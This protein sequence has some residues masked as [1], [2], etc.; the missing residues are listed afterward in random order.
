M[1][2]TSAALRASISAALSEAFRTKGRVDARAVVLRL[3]VVLASRLFEVVV[4]AVVDVPRHRRRPG[5]GFRAEGGRLVGEK[6][7]TRENLNRRAMTGVDGCNSGARLRHGHLSHTLVSSL[8]RRGESS[9]APASAPTPSPQRGRRFACRPGRRSARWPG[10][11]PGRKP[12]S[13][14]ATLPAHLRDGV[15]RP[16]GVVRGAKPLGV[17][18]LIACFPRQIDEAVLA[19]SELGVG[20]GVGGFRRVRRRHRPRLLRIRAVEPLHSV[21]RRLRAHEVGMTSTSAALRASI[22]AALS[23]AFRTKGRVDARAVV[24]RLDVVL[25]SRL[26]EVVVVAVVDV[27]RHRRRP[28]RGFRAEGG[29]LVGKNPRRE[30]ISTAA[31]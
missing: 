4:V 27:P 11:R 31:R 28:G 29:R 18:H 25:A 14:S 20:G 24:L 23:E 9:P 12:G 8:L 5:R 15:R 1:T 13:A 30:R 17:A 16:E 21:A 26:F 6:S 2:S 10:R 22:S 3:D 19:E 7:E